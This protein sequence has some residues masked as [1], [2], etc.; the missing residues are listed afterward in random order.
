MVFPSLSVFSV[1]C[2]VG[3]GPATN[4]SSGWLPPETAHLSWKCWGFEV[5]EC[6]N[7][8]GVWSAPVH[9]CLQ[10]VPS[11]PP[12]S[13][14]WRGWCCC[15]DTSAALTWVVL[16]VQHCPSISSTSFWTPAIVFFMT[17]SV[18]KLNQSLELTKPIGATQYVNLPWGRMKLRYFPA[19]WDS[20]TLWYPLMRSI[21]KN[22]WLP[23][24]TLFQISG[25][26]HLPTRL[27]MLVGV[28]TGCQHWVLAPT[29]TSRRVGR[30]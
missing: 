6:H 9:T 21:L 3:S 17:L 11:L 10:S 20:S 30:C 19:S 5:L 15:L 23:G 12:P 26:W 27:D 4:N 8:V 1:S 13:S 28:D 7:L 29:N 22:L 14:S 25:C 18:N 24:F 16:L 2:S